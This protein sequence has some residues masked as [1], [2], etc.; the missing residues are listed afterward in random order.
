M[1]FTR[2]TLDFLFEN[3]LHDSR[4]WF[5]EH[6]REY[7]ALVLEP[8][9][10]LVSALTPVMLDM[11]GSF[12]VEPKVD[13]TICRIWRDTRYTKDPSLYRDH[14]WI[15][16][17][18]GGKMN[19]SDYPGVYFEI[20]QYGFS[21]GCGFFQPA[22]E[23][24]STLRG[25]VLADSPSFRVADKAYRS[26]KIFL[27]EGD[28]YKRPHYPD[29]PEKK[30][31]WLERRGISFNAQSKDFELLFSDRLPDKLAKDFRAMIPVYR[32]LLEAAEETLRERTA[33]EILQR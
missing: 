14:M 20:G 18:R 31:D 8:L 19:A 32:F 11:D 25:L 29:H 30:R 4:S 2:D 12:N 26:Q 24:L 13:K 3:R 7:Q 15:T 21:Y 10:Q 27:M 28:C 16:F 6:K 1:P 17:R 23:F 33:R 5:A 9:R 22:T